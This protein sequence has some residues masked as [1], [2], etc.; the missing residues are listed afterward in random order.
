MKR[1]MA[2]RKNYTKDE[3]LRQSSLLSMRLSS[4]FAGINTLGCLTVKQKLQ[5]PWDHEFIVLDTNLWSEI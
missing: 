1:N 3:M 5:G 2:I 4:L